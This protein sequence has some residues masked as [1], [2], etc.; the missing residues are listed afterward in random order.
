MKYEI[1]NFSLY[2]HFLILT[3]LLVQLCYVCDI[4]SYI[5]PAEFQSCTTSAY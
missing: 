5:F 2:T 4:L 1:W 3:A